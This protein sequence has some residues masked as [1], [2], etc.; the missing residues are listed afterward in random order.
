MNTP[1]TFLVVP[2][3]QIFSKVK[4]SSTMQLLGL[5]IIQKSKTCIKSSKGTCSVISM[6]WQNRTRYELTNIKKIYLEIQI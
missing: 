5:N 4:Q 6:V 3:F 2:V 1:K